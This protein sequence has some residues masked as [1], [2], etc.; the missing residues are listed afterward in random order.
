MVFGLFRS[1]HKHSGM[2]TAQPYYPP[3]P[4]GGFQWGA[5]PQTPQHNIGYDQWGSQ[6]FQ[7]IMPSQTPGQRSPSKGSR[8]PSKGNRSPSKGSLY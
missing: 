8:S 3:P 5:P 2:P 1:S 7:A 4:Q 6:P